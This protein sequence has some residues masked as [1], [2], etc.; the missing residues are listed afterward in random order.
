MPASCSP[1]ILAASNAAYRLLL[2]ACPGAYRREYGAPMAQ[3]FRDLA[4]EAYR[5]HGAWGLLALWARILPDACSTAVAEHIAA[6]RERRAVAD[7]ELATVG[8][9]SMSINGGAPMRTRLVIGLMV[10]AVALTGTLAVAGI[11]T[12]AVQY[13]PG[14]IK[15]GGGAALAVQAVEGA[16]VRAGRLPLPGTGLVLRQGA[17]E[18]ENV[19]E[20]APQILQ[21]RVQGVRLISG[22]S[23]L[24]SLLNDDAEYKAQVDA[25]VTTADGRETTLSVTL[26]DW[27]LLTPWSFQTQGDGLKPVQVRWM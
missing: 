8:M 4:G 21:V 27:G 20:A 6:H 2:R 9:Q 22:A 26:W 11:Y 18:W 5:R 14:T 13:D 23:L 1:R 24:A 10:L 7:L 25:I 16:L 17:L 19:P 12:P 3:A 15:A